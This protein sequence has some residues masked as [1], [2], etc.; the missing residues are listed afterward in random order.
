MTQ[1]ISGINFI[2]LEDFIKRKWGTNG[3]E[4]YREK[5]GLNYDRIYEERLYPFE[6]YIQCIKTVQELFDDEAAPYQ[7]GW[8]RANNLLLTKGIEDID[9][10]I[11]E[12]VVSAWPKFNNFGD[13]SI[14]KESENKILITISEYKSDPLYCERTRGFFAG[15]VDRASGNGFEVKEVKCVCHGSDHCEYVIES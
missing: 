4:I 11:L 8:H 7:I 14:N 10:E 13:V 9:M 15:L 1:K 3:L 2:H 6:E 12:K 5:N